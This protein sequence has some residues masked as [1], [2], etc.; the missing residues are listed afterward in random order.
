MYIYVCITS[1]KSIK[2]DLCFSR[3]DPSFS[4]VQGCFFLC[5]L[6]Y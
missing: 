5:A 6:N 2:G 3:V 1:R 4:S